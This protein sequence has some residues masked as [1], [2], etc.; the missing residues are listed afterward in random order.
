MNYGLNNTLLNHKMLPR[1]IFRLYSIS[2]VFLPPGSNEAAKNALKC[3]AHHKKFH[4]EK[5][6]YNKEILT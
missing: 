1:E 6:F 5:K 3:T 2:Q 4:F